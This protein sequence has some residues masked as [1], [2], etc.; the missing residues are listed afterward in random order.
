MHNNNEMTPEDAERYFR[1]CIEKIREDRLNNPEAFSEREPG[2]YIGGI[3]MKAGDKLVYDNEG[4][5]VI[6]RKGCFE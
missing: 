1:N 5:Q 3:K 4:F 2:L 6:I